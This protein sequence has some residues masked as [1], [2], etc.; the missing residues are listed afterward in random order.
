MEWAVARGSI[1]HIPTGLFVFN[2]FSFSETHRF[3][4][5]RR[6]Q[7]QKTTL[8]ECLTQFGIQRKIPFLGLDFIGISRFGEAYR[9]IN[10]WLA[11]GSSVSGK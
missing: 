6:I 9:Q 1:K 10:D 5:N 2:A 8:D 11:Q 7:W 3:E 4:R